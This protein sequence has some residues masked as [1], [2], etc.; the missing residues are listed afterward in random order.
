MEELSNASGSIKLTSRTARG[1][2]RDVS[3]KPAPVE[4][5][6]VIGPLGGK[7]L[8]A[9]FGDTTN[10]VT[11][12][13]VRDALMDRLSSTGGR[14]GLSGDGGRQRVQVSAT[15]WRT[16]T[17]IASHVDTGRYRPSPAQVASALIHIALQ[18]FNRQDIVN[19][20]AVA[21][22]E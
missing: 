21:R 9:R 18:G 11:L 5:R 20:L 10:P 17:D 7:S 1:R 13:L 4:A 19:S 2:I 12:M 8:E 6:A 15:D 22:D 16:I 14:P 3:R